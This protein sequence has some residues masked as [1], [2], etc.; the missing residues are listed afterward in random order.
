MAA[1]VE[2][3]GAEEP[4]PVVDRRDVVAVDDG[5]AHDLDRA[6]RIALGELHQIATSELQLGTNAAGLPELAHTMLKLFHNMRAALHV[7][8]QPPDKVPKAIAAWAS[9]TT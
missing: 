1:R 3:V 4:G 8:D 5:Q 7:P 6:V 9:S 2:P